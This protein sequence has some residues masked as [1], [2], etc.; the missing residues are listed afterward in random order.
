MRSGAPTAS[1]MSTC[2][3][4]RSGSGPHS[5]KAAACTRCESSVG[6]KCHF[7]IFPGVQ[8]ASKDVR[9]G[10]DDHHLVLNGATEHKSFGWRTLRP[11]TPTAVEEVLHNPPPR[12]A[13]N[14]SD[15]RKL[16]ACIENIAPHIR[17]IPR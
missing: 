16:Q 15:I 8:R 7:K 3:R 14:G 9:V 2:R 5:P 17:I 6:A 10:I 13:K 11:L 1:A 12:V 4:R